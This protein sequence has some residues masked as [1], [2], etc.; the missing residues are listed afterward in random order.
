M[1]CKVWG[2]YSGVI[3]PLMRLAEL[4]KCIKCRGDG[5][6]I[7]KFPPCVACMSLLPSSIFNPMAL[8]VHIQSLEECT[9][10][11][12]VSHDSELHSIEFVEAKLGGLGCLVA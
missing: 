7:W 4:V 2:C 10:L 8:V 1:G 12:V 5:C 11:G 3:L 6:F 9:L